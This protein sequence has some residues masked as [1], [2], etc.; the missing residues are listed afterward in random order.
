MGA[1]A[2]LTLVCLTEYPSWVGLA[3]AAVVAGSGLIPLIWGPRYVGALMLLDAVLLGVDAHGGRMPPSVAWSLHGVCTAS[4]F[5]MALWP[6][7]EHQNAVS[8]RDVLFPWAAA[9]GIYLG[10]VVGFIWD[11]LSLRAMLGA[12]TLVG[13]VLMIQ[14]CQR[15]WRILYGPRAGVWCAH[16]GFRP[17]GMVASGPARLNPRCCENLPPRALARWSAVISRGNRAIARCGRRR[18]SSRG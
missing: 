17:R 13:A 16:E 6:L 11:A 12:T 10:I 3:S 2:V 9:L 18:T 5:A 4:L 15:A 1:S 8:K 14:S 7:L